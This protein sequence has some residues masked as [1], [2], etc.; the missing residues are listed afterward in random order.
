M[1]DATDFQDVRWRRLVELDAAGEIT[2]EHD[3]EFLREHLPQEDETLAE[4][5]L[6][7][8]LEHWGEEDLLCETSDAPND[9]DER[10]IAAVL[11]HLPLAAAP[12]E[13]PAPVEH[14]VASLPRGEAAWTSA[15]AETDGDTELP[16]GWR[17][18]RT[19][20]ALGIA[21]AMGVL[22]TAMWP[23]P[24]RGEVPQRVASSP[25]AQATATPAEAPERP[26][27]AEP[28][29][30]AVT[31][32]VSIVSGSFV[33]DGQG[34]VLGARL[35]PGAVAR[36]ESPR[37][38]LEN[39]GS[40]ACF[41]HGSRVRVGADELEILQGEGDIDLHTETFAVRV[42][43]T[44]YTSQGP[45]GAHLAVVIGPAQR[46]RVNA[47]G[48]VAVTHASGK[49]ELV[50]GAR[51]FSSPTIGATRA[52]RA[53]SRTA[54]ELLTQARRERADGHPHQALA[55]YE[56]LLKRHGG[57]PLASPA[58][59]AAGQLH[60][61]LGRHRKALRYYERYLAR[62]GALAEEA[63]LGRIEALE[64]LGQA[65]AARDAAAQFR[66]AYPGS[67]YGARLPH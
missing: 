38:C 67:R 66:R 4:R 11:A 3:L 12:A 41:S 26:S 36:V 65:A 18:R 20:W 57:D 55:A 49:Q 34:S 10:L 64:R 32:A 25:S 23:D 60:A 13:E 52:A 16:A 50:E 33:H 39:A 51:T 45:Q 21:A 35:E 48:P 44:R 19:G 14:V 15:Q 24:E 63:S 56:E 40:L 9:A 42:A 62:G 2:S 1:T 47:R 27:A 31:P 43:G 29:S 46:W 7:E 6:L 8:A 22:T 58:L 61:Q 28:G 37:A 59:V 53:P 54:S 5:E 17:N 30:E